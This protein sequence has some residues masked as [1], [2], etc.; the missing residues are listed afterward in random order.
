MQGMGKINLGMDYGDVTV[1]AVG[2][3]NYDQ[4]SGETSM[5]LTTRFNMPVDKGAWQGVAEKILPVEGL[6]FMD[7][8]S[9]TLE[10]AIVE[11]I[12]VKT[13]DK[14]VSDYTIKGEIKKLPSEL[15]ASMIFT[16]VKL[17]SYNL[18]ISEDKGLISNTSSAVLVNMFEK[19]VM[20]YIPFKV[21]FQQT[22]PSNASDRFGLSIDIV[23]GLE[24]YFDY[25][26]SKKDG[27]LNIIT[28]DQAFSDAVNGIKE[29]KRKS[30]NFMYQISTQ[31][32]YLSR[33]LDL[34][35]Q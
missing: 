15:E 19:P 9:N 22:G 4:T 6:R 30:K 12:D 21:F 16:D 28:G 32:A 1:D 11:W 3:V 2:T 7:L 34:F 13:A 18:R 10:M 24:Y 35:A 27:T 14:F 23:G 25:K 26:M 20:K 17:S 29:D 5:N 31:R 33:F 8:S